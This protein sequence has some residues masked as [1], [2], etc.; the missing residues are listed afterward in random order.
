M[1]SEAFL[2]LRPDEVTNQETA[3]R[4]MNYGDLIEEITQKLKDKGIADTES[5]RTSHGYY[6]TGRYLRVHRRFGLWLGIELEVWRDYGITPLWWMFDE[7]EYSGIAGHFHTI[8]GL[9]DDVQLYE[10]QGF[11][12][13]PI[14]L[15]TGVERDRVVDEAVT[16]MNR[17]A[18]KLRETFPDN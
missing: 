5:L 2:P 16:Q 11:L 10:D 15:K 12:Y 3:L 14:R 4:M 6:T 7:S 1:D 8:C 9:F 17:I 18:D 13:I